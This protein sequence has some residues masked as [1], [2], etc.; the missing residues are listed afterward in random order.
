MASRATAVQPDPSQGTPPGAADGH[1]GLLVGP[2]A[3]STLSPFM[4]CTGT[5]LSS[6]T[7]HTQ[8]TQVLCRAPRGSEGENAYSLMGTV[9]ELR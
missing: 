7:T 3:P 8:G 5:R 1:S 6:P 4:L 2:A 9:C